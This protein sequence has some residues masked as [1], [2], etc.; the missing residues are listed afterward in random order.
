[1]P[2]VPGEPGP[3]SAS[4]ATDRRLAPD[5]EIGASVRKKRRV[6]PKVQNQS[7]EAKSAIVL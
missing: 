3:S 4:S 2:A 5:V 6:P 7:S 1:M